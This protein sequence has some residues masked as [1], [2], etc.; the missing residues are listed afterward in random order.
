VLAEGRYL[1]L[2]VTDSGD[3]F[4]SGDVSRLFQPFISHARRKTA[5]G[6]GLNFATAILQRRQGAMSV[7]RAE[8]TRFVAIMPLT[9]PADDT[10][11]TEAPDEARILIV[12]PL[13]QWGVAA[14]TLFSALGRVSTC[15]VSAKAAAELLES[16]SPERHI[17]ILHASRTAVPM[18]DLIALRDALARRMNVDL[19]ILV[20]SAL[21]A[22]PDIAAT[23]G[24]MAAIALGSDAEPADV[25]N[26]LIPNI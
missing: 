5:L 7:A 10:P 19:L 25:V 6:L 20:G 1:A 8:E 16:A 23:L 3:G 13:A 17:V 14:A 2:S 11:S 4:P 15:I 12:D 24:D 22:H 26:F 21:P 9:G 18:E